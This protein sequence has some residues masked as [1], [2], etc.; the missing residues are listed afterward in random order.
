M[1]LFEDPKVKLWRKQWEAKIARQELLRPRPKQPEPSA[2]K[3]IGGTFIDWGRMVVSHPVAGLTYLVLGQIPGLPDAV[4]IKGA[5][6]LT[7]TE[8][9]I[10]QID[11]SAAILMK[12]AAVAETEEQRRQLTNTAAGY[13]QHTS[14]QAAEARAAISPR[15]L[16][17]SHLKLRKFKLNPFYA[18]Q[19][20]HAF[21]AISAAERFDRPQFQAA[22]SLESFKHAPKREAAKR[23]INRFLERRG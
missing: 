7:G 6:A 2:L 19:Q 21:R 13:L 10:T 5:K 4:A 20:A 14:N 22:K 3:E 23:Q 18:Q 12:K 11:P 16:E 17:L 1:A 8:L 15:A 9:K